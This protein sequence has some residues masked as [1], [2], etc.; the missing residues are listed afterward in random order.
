MPDRVAL[1]A[2]PEELRETLGIALDASSLDVTKE[3]MD[4][5]DH[6]GETSWSKS[7]LKRL[8]QIKKGGALLDLAVLFVGVYEMYTKEKAPSVTDCSTSAAL[9]LAVLAFRADI[10]RLSCIGLKSAA[11]RILKADLQDHP[12][13][14]STR[15]CVGLKHIMSGS[16]TL[17]LGPWSFLI[18]DYT[19][20]ATVLSEAARVMDAC[21]RAWLDRGKVPQQTEQSKKDKRGWLD[22]GKVSQ[23]TDAQQSLA[24]LQ[25]VVGPSILAR[26]S[27]AQAPSLVALAGV[28]KTD[29]AL[30]ILH[31]CDNI[32]IHAGGAVLSACTM[33]AEPAETDAL[34]KVKGAMAE[35]DAELKGE[36]ATSKTCI[37]VRLDGRH[38]TKVCEYICEA[39]ESGRVVIDMSEATAASCNQK[40]AKTELRKFK[41]TDAYP[42][43]SLLGET[44][45]ETAN[46]AS[47]DGC[48][49][50]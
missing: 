38:T 32:R 2:L 14:R 29:A 33:Q 22:R 7:G 15:A 24:M 47:S 25:L 11:T 18:A 12:Y 21:K 50:M 19:W 36:S 4:M 37:F 42:Y 43:V 20:S 26:L 48:A 3:A 35:V 41:L 10:L 44:P 27:D 40:R 31:L 49:L 17:A 1:S 34:Q 28:T 23:Q 30:S 9:V 6:H 16:L 13:N 39:I 46:E 8:M 5:L 45:K